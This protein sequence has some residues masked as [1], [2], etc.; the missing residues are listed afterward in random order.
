MIR[1]L[2]LQYRMGKVTEEQ[3]QKLVEKGIITEEEKTT[4]MS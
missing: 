3:L 4:I 2:T 1:F